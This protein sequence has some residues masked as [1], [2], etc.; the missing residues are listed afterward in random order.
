M[1]AGWLG[2]VFRRARGTELRDGVV[3]VYG[4]RQSTRYCCRQELVPGPAAV[5]GIAPEAA[6][7]D[8]ASSLFSS[9][10]LQVNR[11]DK[12]CAGHCHRRLPSAF[13]DIAN[14]LA[15]SSAVNQIG[16][17]PGTPQGQQLN[18]LCW[19]RKL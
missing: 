17:L 9:V 8:I 4:P 15:I 16:R 11:A 10:E 19:F 5:V 18:R 2:F 7:V 12:Q 14:Y 6:V 3:H 1:L 13:S